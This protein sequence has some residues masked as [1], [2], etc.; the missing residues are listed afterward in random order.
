MTL[1]LLLGLAAIIVAFVLIVA[2]QPAAFTIARQTAIN[3]A[4]KDVFGYANDLHKFQEFSPFVD[5]DP[6]AKTEFTGPAAGVGAVF[7]WNGNNKAGQGV[8]TVIESRPPELVR[9]RL[10]FLRPFKA[11][12]TA[13]FTFKPQGGQTVAIWSMSGKNNFMGKTFSLCL[14]SDKMIGREFE[15]GLAKLKQL[16]ERVAVK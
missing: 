4:P 9:L 11:T 5:F 13:E 6:A 15:K 12:N 3:A 10:E 8:M 1:Y 7:K 2:L 16:C 14:N